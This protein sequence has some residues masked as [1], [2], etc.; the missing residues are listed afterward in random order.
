MQLYNLSS[1]N[2]TGLQFLIY[3]FFF[4][5]LHSDSSFPSNISSQFCPPSPH[6]PFRKGRTSQGY[7]PSITYEVAV[8]PGIFPHIKAGG[9]KPVGG[10]GSQ[11]RQESVSPSF[12]VRNPKEHKMY[13]SI[14][15]MQR[16]QG[17]PMQVLYLSL[18]FL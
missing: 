5:I 18:R 6:Y 13:T 11:N 4:H 14:T 3:L 10:T 17:R 16:I 2:L 12:T 1:L 15:Y 9:D 7:Q 8:K